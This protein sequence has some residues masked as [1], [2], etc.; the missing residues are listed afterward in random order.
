MLDHIAELVSVVLVSNCCEFFD[1]FSADVVSYSRSTNKS[2]YDKLPVASMS[3]LSSLSCIIMRSMSSA[4][5]CVS[6][7]FSSCWSACCGYRMII[8]MVCEHIIQRH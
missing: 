1:V 4:S 2:Y 6:P 7:S 3:L 8:I 5:D